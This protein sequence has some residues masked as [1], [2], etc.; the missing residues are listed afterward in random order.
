[1]PLEVAQDRLRLQL[2]V[3][4]LN[5]SLRSHNPSSFAGIYVDHRPEDQVVAIFTNGGNESIDAEQ[6]DSSLAPSLQ[7]REVL[8]SLADLEREQHRLATS[9]G[10]QASVDIDLRANRVRVEVVEEAAFHEVTAI[11]SE[12]AY[13][14]VVPEL[15]SP[16]V[17]LFGGLASSTCTSGFTIYY[18]TNTTNRGIATAGHCPN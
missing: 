18:G 15:P 8:F 16:A 13:G 12:S 10:R 17:N 3:G 6:V 14:V 5:E 9:L 11:L 1:V 4:Q 7:I 2:Q